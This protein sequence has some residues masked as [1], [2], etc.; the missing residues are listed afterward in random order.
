MY[1]NP[2]SFNVEKLWDFVYCRIFHKKIFFFLI[3]VGDGSQKTEI[4]RRKLRP[5][6][7]SCDK[8]VDIYIFT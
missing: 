7:K 3:F 5:E 4:Y 6:V 2:E 8:E 1:E